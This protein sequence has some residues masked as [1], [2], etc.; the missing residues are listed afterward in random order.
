MEPPDWI[1]AT[2]EVLREAM[3]STNLNKIEIMHSIA[4]S[5]GMLHCENLS[6]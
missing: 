5:T 4:F 3:I 6:I 2:E 1:T